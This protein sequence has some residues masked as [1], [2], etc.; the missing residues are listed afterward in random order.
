MG[1]SHDQR[2]SASRSDS[3]A[4]DRLSYGDLN[5]SDS[6]KFFLN[7]RQNFTCSDVKI[8]IYPGYSQATEHALCR[9][10]LPRAEPE[11]A[12]PPAAPT[13][14]RLLRLTAIRALFL[15][16]G[17]DPLDMLKEKLFLRNEITLKKARA[18]LSRA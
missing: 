8:V 2:S 4:S 17:H 15:G 7:I 10:L 6:Q 9:K 1:R 5:Y 11:G 12:A 16:I 14:R 13:R 18:F 3:T